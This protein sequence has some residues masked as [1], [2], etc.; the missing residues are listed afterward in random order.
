MMYVALAACCC[1]SSSSGVG[2]FLFRGKLG[3]GGS[4]K[5]KVLG[6]FNDVINRSPKAKYKRRA[7]NGVARVTRMGAKLEKQNPAKAARFWA[8]MWSNISKNKARI[9]RKAGL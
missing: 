3:L 2:A 7:R 8:K 9:L 4:D 5:Q 6:F 1:S